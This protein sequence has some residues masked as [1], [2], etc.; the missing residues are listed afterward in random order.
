[1]KIYKYLQ[2]TSPGGA[3]NRIFSLVWRSSVKSQRGKGAGS[4]ERETCGERGARNL[5]VKVG[6]LKGRGIPDAIFN[7][8]CVTST[9][10]ASGRIMP[11]AAVRNNAF[12]LV[13]PPAPGFIFLKRGAISKYGIHDAPRLLY[14]VVARKQRRIASDRVAQ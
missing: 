13:R 6:S 4:G 9:S 3:V 11:M 12:R 8:S 2:I 5:R 14:A 7:V 10:T 1:M